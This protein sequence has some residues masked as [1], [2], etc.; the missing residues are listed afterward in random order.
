MFDPIKSDLEMLN[1]RGIIYSSLQNSCSKN[2]LLS[3]VTKVF[4]DRD[5]CPNRE[6]TNILSAQI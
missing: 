5:Y 4:M 6:I 1:N 3:K 2:A